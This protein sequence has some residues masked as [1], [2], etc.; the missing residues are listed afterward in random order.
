LAEKYRIKRE[1]GRK[2]KKITA[3]NITVSSKGFEVVITKLYNYISLEY[4]IVVV[5]D[6][7][8]A[9]LRHCISTYRDS[10]PNSTLQK[11]KVQCS[12]LPF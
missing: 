9:F 12:Y 1:K 5:I 7:G 11:F 6:T 10:A 2:E 4:T 8:F 3:K